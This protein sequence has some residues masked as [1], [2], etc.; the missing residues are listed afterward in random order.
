M[1]AEMYCQLP[2]ASVLHWDYR[3]YKHTMD[4]FQVK[5][6]SITTRKSTA[7]KMREVRK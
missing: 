2:G 4:S 1:N 3:K 6:G 7:K 5:K